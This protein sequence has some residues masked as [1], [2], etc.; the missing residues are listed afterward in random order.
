MFVQKESPDQIRFCFYA[1][2]I[3]LQFAYHVCEFNI[4][5]E[6][7]ELRYILIREKAKVK[8][9]DF[10]EVMK[11]INSEFIPERGAIQSCWQICPQNIWKFCE[12][13]S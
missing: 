12:K 2:P 10:A 6:G 4:V 8:S 3:P 7:K 9:T 5:F 13:R 1:E 11:I